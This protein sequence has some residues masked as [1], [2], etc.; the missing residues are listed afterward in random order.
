MIYCVTPSAVSQELVKMSVLQSDTVI[1]LEG[2]QGAEET[3][4]DLS[5]DFTAWHLVRVFLKRSS[6]QTFM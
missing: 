5:D 1:R 6:T 3:E 4:I 2:L